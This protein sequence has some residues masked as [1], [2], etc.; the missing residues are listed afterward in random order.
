MTAKQMLPLRDDD[1][2]AE[3]EL[4]LGARLLAHAQ[5]LAR[6]EARKRRVWNAL[7]A[8]HESRLG[9]RLTALHVAFASVFFAAASSAAVGGYYVKQRAQADTQAPAATPSVTELAKPPATRKRRASLPAAGHTESP[10]VEPALPT[11]AP[12][13][14]ARDN[15]APRTPAAR[16]QGAPGTARKAAAQ[17][18][19]AELLVEAMRAR[20]N[21]DAARV[22]QLVDEYRAR[23]PRGALQE[24]ALILSLESAVG[25]RAPNAASLAREYLQRFPNGRFASQARRALATAP[26]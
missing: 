1:A 18:A 20:S 3:P 12:A 8:G 19:D 14:E 9:F 4:R 7:S 13:A 5:P 17:E 22:S 11:P 2:L 24:E 6:S 15:A 25:R 26:R 10:Q 16:P 23:Q 21:G